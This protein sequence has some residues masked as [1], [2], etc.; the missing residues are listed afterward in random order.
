[1]LFLSCLA[2][3]SNKHLSLLFVF[4]AR[5]LRWLSAAMTALRHIGGRSLVLVVSSRLAAF[6]ARLRRRQE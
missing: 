5:K 6:V 4:C 1:M 2:V 3:N